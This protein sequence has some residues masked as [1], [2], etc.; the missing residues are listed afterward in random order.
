MIGSIPVDHLDR[1]SY[2]TGPTTGDSPHLLLATTLSAIR[3]SLAAMIRRPTVLRGILSPALAIRRMI[4]GRGRNHQHRILTSMSK[5]FAED[6]LLAVPEFEGQFRID[7]R[8]H[9]FSRLILDGSYEPEIAQICLAHMDRGRDAIDIGANIGFF[10]VLIGKHLSAGRRVL[11]VEPTTNALGKLH[12]N[13]D[14]NGIRSKTIVYEGVAS[15]EP[16]QVTIN[17]I[18]GKE[19][20]SSLGPLDHPSI[21][22]EVSESYSVPAST[23]DT[24]IG[25]FHLDPGFM[26]IDV[27][28]AEHLVLMGARNTLL[29]HRPVILSELT[30]SLLRQNQSSSA[31]VIEYL[32]SLG[33]DVINPFD[34]SS[35]AGSR[36]FETILCLPRPAPPRTTRI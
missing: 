32:N 6:P 16:G 17:T 10:S 23:V 11:A 4:I 8:S 29:T 35:P 15:S 24:L 27:E 13:I 3:Q 21:R 14:G 25:Q 7:V 5:R 30:D 2:A 9:L 36:D 28:G 20:Y 1:L 22:G 26:K 31:Q 34:R 33:Y 19:E 12:R 18:A